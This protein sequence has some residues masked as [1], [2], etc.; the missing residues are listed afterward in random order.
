MGY[1]DK[2][3]QLRA[4]HTQDTSIC[5]RLPY[6]SAQFLIAQRVWLENCSLA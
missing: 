4:I 3:A 2:D 6:H 5:T 1:V